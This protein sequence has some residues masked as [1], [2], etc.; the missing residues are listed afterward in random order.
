M[1]A[2]LCTGTAVATLLA[3]LAEPAAAASA[4]GSHAQFRHIRLEVPAFPSGMLVRQRPLEL[5]EIASLEFQ[6]ATITWKMN[7]LMGAIRLFLQSA[8]KGH[9]VGEY[10]FRWGQYHEL[11]PPDINQ[12]IR[13]YSRGAR[14]NHKACTTMLGKLHL[15]L[16]QKEK[17]KQLLVKTAAPESIGGARGDSLAQ[18]FLAE[19]SLGAGKLRDAVRWWKRSAENGDIDAMMRLAKLFTQ[20][21]I[22]IPREEMRARHWLLAAAAHG[23]QEALGQVSTDLSGAGDRPKV[24]RVWIKHMEEQ[25]WC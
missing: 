5:E 21:G 24:E 16:G 23:H 17:A 8:Q 11:P 19:L 6:Q 4:A 1:G 10:C 7:N 9:E 14:M 22:G 25:G 15:A 20:G 18:W 13:W 3:T 12:A 2:A